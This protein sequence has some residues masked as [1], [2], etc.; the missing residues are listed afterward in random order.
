MDKPK[1]NTRNPGNCT[2]EATQVNHTT[3]T[4]NDVPAPGGTTPQFRIL[5]RKKDPVTLG[6][7]ILLKPALSI[8]HLSKGPL[9][10]TFKVVILI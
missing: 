2:T 4:A 3:S 10:L 7:L 8:V 6:T 5:L 1:H 9:N